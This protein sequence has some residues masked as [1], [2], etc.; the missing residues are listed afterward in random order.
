[1]AVVVKAYTS[2]FSWVC[3]A[4]VYRVLVR[5]C[6]G[7]GGGGGGKSGIVTTASEYQGGGGG[8]GA[9]IGSESVAVVPGTTYNGVI[10][11]PGDGGAADASGTNGAASTFGTGG[12]AAVNF[13]GGQSGKCGSNGVGL[14]TLYRRNLPGG[15]FAVSNDSSFADGSVAE[16]T[17][18]AATI[19]YENFTIKSMPGSGGRSK[20]AG[21]RS[22]STRFVG[23]AAGTGGADSGSY[24]GGTGGGGGGAGPF[25]DGGAGGNG[26]A[27]NGAGAGAIGSA[28]SNATVNGGGGGGGG[29][30]GGCGTASGGAGGI[31][32]FGGKGYMELIYEVG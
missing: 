30:A 9:A 18:D 28:G 7:G 1:M 20:T 10:G 16:Q 31:G 5:G 25:G 8:G 2:D 13:L 23:G 15:A 11:L 24:I 21:E 26:G 4:G 6:G 3:P 22:F 32:G 17:V 14:G 12:V 27:G 19:G 29:G